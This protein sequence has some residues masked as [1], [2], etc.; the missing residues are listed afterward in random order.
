MSGCH[1]ACAERREARR[2]TASPRSLALVGMADFAKAFPHQLSGGMK[3]RV[4][5]ARALT[6][7]PSAPLDGRAFRGARRNDPFSPERRSV[8]AATSARLHSRLRH[9]FDLRERRICRTASPSCRP[10]PAAW[11]RKFGSKKRANA[12]PISAP[13]RAMHKPA[14]TCRAFWRTAIR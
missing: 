4:S 1:C 12:T 7:R 2:A 3:M 9:P 8:D 11:S 10:A 5:I 6:L 14:A 13:A